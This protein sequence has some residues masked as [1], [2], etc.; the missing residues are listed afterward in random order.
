MS[1]TRL[2]IAPRSP[3]EGAPLAATLSPAGYALSVVGDMAAAMAVFENAP[4]SLAIVDVDFANGEG[5]R[6]LDMLRQAYPQVP[7]LVTDAEGRIETA[8]LATRA[9]ARDYLAGPLD[10]VRLLTLVVN[11]LAKAGANAGGR[12]DKLIGSSKP[13]QRV[14]QKIRSVATSTAT[15]FLTGE[16]GT[17][18]D[19]CA[20][21]IHASSSRAQGAFVAVNCALPGGLFERQLLGHDAD[22]GTV[23]EA[24]LAAQADGGTLYFDEICALDQAAQACL[25]RFVQGLSAQAPGARKQSRVNV[26]IICATKFDPRTAVTEGVLR[27][28]LFY[29]LHVI[30]IHL[31]PLRERGADMAEIATG[32]LEAIS[33]Q[34]GRAFTS[35]EAAALELLGRQAWPGNVRQLQNVIRQ[36][37]VLND[38]AEVTRAMLPEELNLAGPIDADEPQAAP[39]DELGPFL[40][41]SLAEIEQAVIAATLK[42]TGGSVT[43]AAR[44][45]KV[46]PSTLY[47]KLEAWDINP[48][49]ED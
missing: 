19:L 36:I 25:L 38:A 3:A 32:L 39:G 28:D 29:R 4:P 31:P 49:A 22:T 48:E 12:L 2:L 43:R 15:V 11:V 46:A 40:G 6:L 35:F 7:V 26:R 10:K 47:R 33:A 45:L 30:P 8:V 42:M 44:V 24:G 9:G 27:E 13:M 34:E 41:K 37:V 1:R 21:V 23:G 17:G 18:K 5:L 14:Q 20:Q 16:S